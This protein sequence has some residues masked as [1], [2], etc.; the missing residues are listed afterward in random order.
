MVYVSKKLNHVGLNAF[1]NEYMALCECSKA[2]VWMRQLLH[3]LDEPDLITKPTLCFG[4]NNAS[5]QLCLEDFVS[6][7]NQYIY[8]PYHYCKEV[9][10][11][12]YID[13][14]QKRTKFN[15]AD[16]FTKAM[17]SVQQSIHATTLWHGLSK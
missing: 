7:G 6:T 9:A 17:N 8:L 12:G 3:E 5:I 16:I 15:L 1:H 2:I 13:F 14:K 11:N 10:N 4:D